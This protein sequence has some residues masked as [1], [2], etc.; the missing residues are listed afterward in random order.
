M[1]AA[2]TRRRLGGAVLLLAGIVVAAIVLWPSGRAKAPPLPERL[3]FR[4]VSVPPLG[5]GF[6]Y[7]RSWDRSVQG[8]VITLSSRDQSTLVIFS[9]PLARPARERVKDEAQRALRKRFA[10]AEVVRE[11]PGTIGNRSAA[12]FELR[13]RDR[14]GAVRALVLVSSTPYR[15]YAVTILTGARP[16]AQGLREARQILGTVRFSRPLRSRR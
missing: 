8:Q 16:S 13:G 3:P 6:A 15:T 9:S 1:T 11:S 12:S 5:L 14:S 4:I 10:P 7:P 2:L